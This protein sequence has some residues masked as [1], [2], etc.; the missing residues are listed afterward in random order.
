MPCLVLSC[1]ALSCFILIVL[2]Y[3]LVPAERAYQT[4]YALKVFLQ[5]KLPDVIRM[6]PCSFEDVVWGQ[7]GLSQPIPPPQ[8]DVPPTISVIVSVLPI[9]SYLV[10]SYLSCVALRFL[11]LSCVAFVVSWSCLA[12]PCLVLS[13]LVSSRFIF[14]CLSCLVLSCLVLYCPNLPS[15]KAGRWQLMLC[16]PVRRQRVLISDWSFIISDWK[17]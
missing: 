9:L 6:V 14:S 11:T 2:S 7:R 5:N 4:S 13:W 15:R 17:G 8:K 10:V 1:L 12:L 16:L 3:I